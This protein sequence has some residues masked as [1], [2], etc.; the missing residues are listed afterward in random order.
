MGT[1]E[2][3]DSLFIK[4]DYRANF[5]QV[6][7]KR[8]DLAKFDGGRMKYAGVG[9]TAVYEAGLVVGYATSGADSG[10]YKPYNSANSDGSQ[11]AVGVLSE[12]VV[13]DEF[14]NGSQAAILKSATV[15]QSALIGYDATAKTTLAAKESVEHGV[16]LVSF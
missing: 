1:Q 12:Q 6:I 7:A 2:Y 9:L 13:T 11:V 14:G 5:K 15:F 16:N 8:S 4:E 10:K 3:K